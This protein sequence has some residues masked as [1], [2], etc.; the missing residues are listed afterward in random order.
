MNVREQSFDFTFDYLTAMM[1]LI[2]LVVQVS[3]VLGAAELQAATEAQVAAGEMQPDAAE[4]SDNVGQGLGIVGLLIVETLLI[5]GLWRVWE[6]LPE[7][8]R[9]VVLGTGISVVVG[10]VLL[11]FY[12]VGALRAGPIV[13]G[14]VAGCIGISSGL[15]RLA[16]RYDVYWLLHNTIGG[17]IGILGAVVFGRALAPVVIILMLVLLLIWD[18]VAVNVTDVMDGLFDA[19]DGIGIPAYFVLPTTLRIDMDAITE[20]I[21]NYPDVESP[22]GL[23]GIIG[24]GDFTIPAILTVSAYIAGTR[25]LAVTTLLGTVG[26]IIALRDTHA[27]ADEGLPALLWVNSGALFGFGAGVLFTGISLTTALGVSL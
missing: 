12:S 14:I 15:I 23:G 10:T 8:A 25:P 27:K 13:I 1:V 3:A 5:I 16:K 26:G 19:V 21:D 11:Y 7:W 6:R 20:Y 18:H 24:V 22:D 17:F 9:K 4:Q 2:V